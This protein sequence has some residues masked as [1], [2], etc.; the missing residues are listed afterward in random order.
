MACS[1]VFP[2]HG[3]AAPAEVRT[4]ADSIE[5]RPMP[6]YEF[7]CTGCGHKFSQ[8]MSLAEYDKNK[9]VCPK[10]K[11]ERVEQVIADF[12]VVTAKKS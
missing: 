7:V 5:V 1:I 3:P 6:V 11:G 2:I 9:V 4:G 12:Y 10:C 8:I